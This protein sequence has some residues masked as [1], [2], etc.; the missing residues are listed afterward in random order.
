MSYWSRLIIAVFAVLSS[1]RPVS[2]DQPIP[3]NAL[4]QDAFEYA[5][6]YHVP[7]AQARQRLQWQVLAGRLEEK[8]VVQ[9]PGSFAGLWIDHAPV[10]RVVVLMTQPDKA[11]TAVARML[12]DSPLNDRV[13]IRYV[14]RTLGEL[15]ELKALAITAVTALGE[16]ADFDIDVRANRVVLYTRNQDQINHFLL[17]N[18]LALP[19]GVRVEEVEM[20]ASPTADVYGGLPGGGCTL[21]FSVV[22]SNGNL[23]ISSAGHCIDTLFYTSSYLPIQGECYHDN[24]DVQ[25]HTDGSH[26]ARPRIKTGSVTRDIYWA[27]GRSLQPIGAHVCKQGNTT[28]FNCGSI[29]S[30]NFAPSYVPSA[31]STFIRVD[32]GSTSLS[33]PG[34]SGGPWVNGHRA[35]GI[36][37]GRIGSDAIYMPINYLSCLNV[38]VLTTPAPPIDPSCEAACEDEYDDCQVDFCYWDYNEFMC[39]EGCYY[40]FNQCLDDCYD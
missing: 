20:L 31:N 7:M 36:N 1:L 15:R 25:W 30:K 32:G 19:R 3:K 9:Y 21:G 10:F 40:E 28:G 17:S 34:D 16:L 18:R 26:T 12:T 14:D 22:D 5:Q 24:Y 8:L 35:Y 27:D 38:S 4:S 33:L 29:V 11:R 39:S 6:R 23:G 13:E 2:A 37:S